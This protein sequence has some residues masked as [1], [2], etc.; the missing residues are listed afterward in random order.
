MHWVGKPPS[1]DS[2]I[3]L[4]AVSKIFTVTKEYSLQLRL[5][6]TGGRPC[7][8]DGDT[9]ETVVGVGS[10]SSLQTVRVI[11]EV[12]ALL[13]C[14]KT[15]GWI[16]G[17][18][19]SVPTSSTFRVSMYALDM[20]GLPINHTGVEIRLAFGD[21]NVLMQRIPGSNEYV[22]TLSAEL[23]AQPGHYDLVASASN[24]WD[25]MGPATTC[26][27]LRRTITVN[28]GLSTS[29]ILGGAGATSAVVVGVL[30]VLVRKRKAHLQ[31]I[32]ALLISEVCLAEPNTLRRSCPTCC[33]SSH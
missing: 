26:E 17:N 9:I 27:L 2:D 31:A 7:V 5:D 19:E 10:S 23:T 12:E 6:C 13:S 18:V 4:D 25:E 11:A 21:R 22:A 1:N 15:T 3:N 8:V 20:D 24:A 14:E 28:E 16:E 32:M 29:W 33:T 30:V